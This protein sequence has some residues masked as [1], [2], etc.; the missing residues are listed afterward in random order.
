MKLSNTQAIWHRQRREGAQAFRA[1]E[2]YLDLGPDRS[3]KAVAQRCTKSISIMRR[4]SARWEWMNRAAAYDEHVRIVEEQARQRERARH[5]AEMERR[6]IAVQDEA[7]EMFQK[8]RERVNQMLRFPLQDAT[9][10]DGKTVIK[11]A[12]W[13]FNT[14]PRLVEAL[15]K[16]AAIAVPA[17]DEARINVDWKSLSDEQLD[18][19]AA[20]E[21]V[22]QVIAT[23]FRRPRPTA[24]EEPQRI[25]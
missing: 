16:L 10:P 2:A 17:P 21:D 9:S 20:G 8:L 12:R 23:S 5:A 7:W 13:D 22:F 1:F 15:V 3:L 25:M 4:W 11:A 6:K 19:I 24:A 18:R 14:L